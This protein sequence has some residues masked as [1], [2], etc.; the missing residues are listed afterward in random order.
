MAAICVHLIEGDRLPL[1]FTTALDPAE[2]RDLGV[3]LADHPDLSEL[4]TRATRL[5][6]SDPTPKGP[7]G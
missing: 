5:A 7:A 3:W 6:I 2:E 1:V 4:V